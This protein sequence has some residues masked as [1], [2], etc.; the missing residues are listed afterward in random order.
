MESFGA[1]LRSLREEQG[2]TLEEIAE[3]TKIAVAN[4]DLLERD[5]YELLPPRVFVRGFIRSYMQ[6]LGLSPDESLR[7]F[8]EFTKE[9]ELPDYGVQEPSGFA[10]EKT[11]FSFFH[12]SWFTII[13]TAAGLISL[14][15]LILTG[16]TRFFF[17]DNSGKQSLPVVRTVQPP[18][19]GPAS[20]RNGEAR[21]RQQS[22]VSES[23]R[24]YGGRKVLEIRAVANAW[25]R[26]EAD[27][28]PAEELMMAPGDVQVFTANEG[29]ILQTGNA[30]GLRVR[31]DGKELPSLGKMNQT[32]SLTLP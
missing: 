7:R 16:A 2:K 3:N 11:S 4:L 29:F 28:E 25:I 26:I 20:F 10:Q 15:I 8:E 22:A 13:L 31:Y 21:G 17:E 14:G 6:E 1:Y 12:R 32:L 19:Y 30:G 24:T 9:G 18:G 5:R 27:K 23:R